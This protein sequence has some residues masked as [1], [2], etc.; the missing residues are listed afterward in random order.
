[1]ARLDSGVRRQPTSESMTRPTMVAGL[2][3]LVS[4]LSFIVALIP[5]LKGGD[6]NVTFLGTGVVFLIVAVVNAKK[7]RPPSNRPPAA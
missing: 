1:M 7:G 2:L 5:L 6:M 3:A 4:V